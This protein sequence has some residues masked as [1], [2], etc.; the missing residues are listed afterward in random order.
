MK[1]MLIKEGFKG[2]LYENG[3]FTRLLEPGKHTLRGLFDTTEREVLKVDVR[4]RSTTIK[5]QEILT[6]DKVTVRLSLLVYFKVVD[7]VAAVSKLENFEDRI[8]EDVQLSARRFL[9]TRSL[10]QL[11]LD[12]NDLS[13]AIK[14]DVAA[15]LLA[16]GVDILRA[17]VKDFV[18]PGQLKDVMNKVIETSRQAEATLI[19]TRARLE[20]AALEAKSR[21]EV[22]RL[23]AASRAEA[24]QVEAKAAVAAG[25]EKL[26][27]DE[28]VLELLA[29]HPLLVKV[30][31]LE[32]LERIGSKGN[33]HFYV[34]IDPRE[35]LN[36]HHG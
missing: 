31:E 36:A 33:N 34:G 23:D 35:R 5:N 7:A 12:R 30:K 25:D 18:F 21:A 20:V 19:A 8:Y 28:K 9:A 14:A 24:V 13:N 17:D 2:L 3:V 26:K 4:E 10:D 6:S 11:L 15:S 1:T 22:V 16:Y 27:A 29:K 32:A